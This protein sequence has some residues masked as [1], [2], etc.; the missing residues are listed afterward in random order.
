MPVPATV[1]EFLDVIRKSGLVN[2]DRLQP[3]LN[4]WGTDIAAPTTPEQASSVLMQAGLITKFQARQ[5]KLGRY[6]RFTIAGKY[7]LLELLGVGGMGAVY[8]C[9]HVFM[10]RLVAIKVLPIE[11][12]TDPSNLDRFYREARAV[13]A[14]DH[15]NVVKAYDID[16]ADNLH[17]LVMEYVD[18]TSLQEIV[19]RYGMIDP[20]RAAQYIAQAAVGMHHGHLLSLV[21][22]DIKPGNLLLDRTGVIKLL[23][24]GLARFFD[25]KD[26]N[27]TAK[28]D[29]NCVLG[30]ADY[31]APEQA[32]SNVVDIRADI[33]ALGG[34]F[35]FMLTGVSPVPE[36]T[37]AAK[38][39]FHQTQQ[40]KPV[41]EFRKDVPPGMLAVLTK[42]L[43]KKPAERYQTPME[44]AEALAEWAQI[45]VGPPPEREMPELCPAVIVLSGHSNTPLKMSAAG[46]SRAGGVGGL[47]LLNRPSLGSSVQLAKPGLASEPLTPGNESVQIDD[48]T[49][50]M[51]PTGGRGTGPTIPINPTPGLRPGLMDTPL[52][53][54]A[55]ESSVQVTAF[56]KESRT[57]GLQSQSFQQSPTKGK[58]WLVMALITVILAL[59]TA[60]SVYFAMNPSGRL[61]KVPLVEGFPLPA[62]A[63]VADDAHKYHEHDATVQFRVVN[64]AGNEPLFLDSKASNTVPGCFSVRLE[65]PARNALVREFNSSDLLRQTLKGRVVRVHGSIV[66][67]D[68][69]QASMTI[70]DRSRIE[71]LDM[72]AK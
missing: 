21:H 55:T 4:R 20:I 38:L 62:G 12:L 51:T 64:L 72:T 53:S 29:D 26:D 58:P 45:D 60:G 43:K 6:K 42:M 56:P 30:T 34:T 63:I 18:G 41:T 35:Y 66:V 61:G 15:P 40:P 44:V 8:L 14:L 10:K 48:L 16:K 23:D 11:K 54:A 19:A 5:F 31:L 28:Y 9:E 36:G 57:F 32:I 13:A 52:P 46:A 68:K 37:V 33:Y 2:E 47:A 39:V 59:L 65:N 50:A 69:G 49:Q 67:D 7:R 3:E 1:P 24:M 70:S 71:I 22:R 27:L 25:D 17:F